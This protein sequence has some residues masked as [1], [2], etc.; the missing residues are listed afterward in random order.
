MHNL[1]S[2]NKAKADAMR[3]ARLGITDNRTADQKI[4]DANRGDAAGEPTREERVAELWKQYRALNSASEKRA[5][6]LEHRA[7]LNPFDR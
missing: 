2:S 7:I 6:Y 5:F 1:S 4:K 3:K